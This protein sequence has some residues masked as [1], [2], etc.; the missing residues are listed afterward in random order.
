MKETTGKQEKKSSSLPKAVKTKQEIIE[1]KQSNLKLRNWNKAR[2]LVAG[3]DG[4]N[5]NINIDVCDSI[6]TIFINC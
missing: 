4:L 1:K 3:C 2:P 5:G 6:E